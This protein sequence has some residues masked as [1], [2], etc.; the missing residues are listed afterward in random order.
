MLSHTLSLIA[1]DGSRRWRRA[2]TSLDS[3]NKNGRIDLELVESLETPLDRASQVFTAASDEVNGVDSSGFLG[4]FDHKYDDYADQLDSAASSLRAASRAVDVL[5]DMIGADG[6]RDYLLLFQ[7]NAEIRATGGMPGS[8]ARI[9]AERGKIEMV[10]QGTAGDFPRAQTPVVPLTSAEEAVYG[11]EYGLFFQDPGFAPDFQRGAEMWQAHWQ[12]Q[13]P[14]IE[15]DGVLALDPVGMS[16]L[17]DGTGPVTV[18]GRRLTSDNVVE[19]LLNRPYLEL[20][21][22]AQNEFF[23][24]AARAI[25]ESAT[26]SLDSPVAL[27]EGLGRAAREGRFL[28]APFH[29]SDLAKLEGSRV[30]G[31]LTG[32]DGKTPHVDIGVNDATGSK[33]SYYLR[34]R[35][36][37]DSRSCQDGR[38]QLSARMT[39]RQTISPSEAA[40]LP[41]S[42]TGGGYYGTEPGLQTVLFRLYGPYDGSISDILIDGKR[43]QVSEQNVKID[44]R[45]VVTVP[46]EL[47]SR[48]DVVVTWEMESGPNQTEDG[49]L[50]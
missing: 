26:G 8:W 13:F 3:L 47:S 42:V 37:V 43:I 49:R 6:P 18:D 34:Y 4:I 33:M 46:I 7:N 48:D 21:P 1:T 41:D 50:G 2:S 28:V 12:R 5:P 19:E 25:F 30:L 23:A 27:V 35:A 22:A 31:E 39:V 14:E 15:L 36:D 9:H 44:G 17:L 40:Q 29:D 16:Y 24:A 10:E 38:Q 11:K 32:D 45:P 20:D